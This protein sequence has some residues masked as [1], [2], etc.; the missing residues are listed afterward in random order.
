M[1]RTFVALWP[2]AEAA[3]RLGEEARLA[4]AQHGGRPM[5]GVDLHVTLA[6]IGELAPEASAP[7]AARLRSRLHAACPPTGATI[8]FDRIDSFRGANVIWLGASAP[9]GWLQLLA[10]AVR[11]GLDDAGVP[12]DRKPF[13]PHLTVARGA[14]A[15]AGPIGALAVSG[16]RVA[17][18]RSIEPAAAGAGR[19]RVLEW[20]SPPGRP[21]GCNP[22]VTAVS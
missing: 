6:F 8:V 21:H 20:L 14:R 2:P 22:H 17:L 7:L 5:P 12:F 10:D 3:R 19:Y 18:V 4:A 11:D 13:V 9:P 16:W 15:P 1:A